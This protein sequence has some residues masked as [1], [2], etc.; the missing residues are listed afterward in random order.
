MHSTDSATLRNAAFE[1]A[2]TL[3]AAAEVHL[4][5]RDVTAGRVWAEGA[6][7][8]RLA[9][10]VPE[11]ALHAAGLTSARLTVEGDTL[12][13]TGTLN[14]LHVTHPLRLPAEQP[15]LEEQ[16]TLTNPG[17][18]AERVT[19]FAFGFRRPIANITGHVST[20]LAADRVAAIP[21]RHRATDPGAQDMDFSLPELM[22]QLNRA[23]RVNFDHLITG[24]APTP[25]W[26][27]EGWA[28]TSGGRTLGVFKFNPTA[29]EWSVVE[30]ETEPRR[31]IWL[32]FG[33]AGQ[34]EGE[35]DSLRTLAPGQS[36]ALGVTRLV[37]VADY[38]AAAYA[39]RALL[40]EHGCR[41]P[42]GFN[43]PVH[44][45]ELYDNP[46][47]STG[48][49]GNP[50]GPRR[51]RAHTYTRAKLFEEAAKAQAYGCQALYLDPGWDVEFGSLLWA[52]EWLGDLPSF[53]AEVRERFG[54]SVSLHCP[55]AAWASVWSFDSHLWPAEANRLTEAG[56]HLPRRMCQASQQY[57]DEV[58]RRLLTLCA[59]GVK[60]LMFDGNAWP[61]DCWDPA[62]GHSVPLTYNE[63]CAAN[64]ELARRVHAA[65][66][67][68]I[69]E[70]HDAIVA[71]MRARY[72]PVYYGYELA[73]DQRPG[74][75]DE[76]WGFELMWQPMEEIE[77]GR[78]RALYYYNLACNVPVY[79]HVDLRT[80]NAHALLL[81]WYASTCRH[82][83]IG[84]THPNPQI[85]ALHRAYMAQYIELERF[86][87]EG[88]FFGIHEGFH[89]HV[90]RDQ[91]AF[92]VNLFNFSDQ[93]C[94]ISGSV[95]F[96]QLGLPRDRWYVAPFTHPEGYFDG[97]AGTFNLNRRVPAWGTEVFQVYALPA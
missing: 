16:F 81:W 17:S 69:I 25:A 41:F 13:I 83:G 43:P 39:F 56:E 80:D 62:H 57:M 38:T 55:L 64:S 26:A 95:S 10:A 76:N 87:K 40:D 52:D 84:G 96:E 53:V 70:M 59:G 61:G 32:R 35:P 4:T 1:L 91:G 71:G 29:L 2:A 88:E 15:W 20:E 33:G 73:S 5:L 90:L 79:L 34:L 65:Y 49:P 93:P 72:T 21:F 50:P 77:T 9:R 45:N 27:S 28:L 94:T 23:P 74:T 97:G 89:V 92:V 48:T 24:Y 11:G 78:A 63:H 7:T 85:A 19:S 66:P 36:V 42:A 86:F 44:W 3:T 30:V 60:F 8:Y 6:Y 68:V 46:E 31:A 75:W 22:A 18:A 82:L 14:G 47:W 51:T 54:L 67:D 12:T 58:T 37:S